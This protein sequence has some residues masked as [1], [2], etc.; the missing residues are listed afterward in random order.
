ML[1]HATAAAIGLRDRLDAQAV[2]W[3]VTKWPL[4]QRPVDEW[5][6]SDREAF[7][8]YRGDI[9]PVAEA[10]DLSELAQ[11]LLLDVEYLREI[12]EPLWMVTRLTATLRRLSPRP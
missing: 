8:Q 4:D 7:A 5:S 12:E 1:E 10:G 2:V 11:A 6:A 9:P 3:S